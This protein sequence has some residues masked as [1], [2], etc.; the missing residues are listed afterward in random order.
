[1]AEQ[2]RNRRVPSEEDWG[3]R[4][5]SELFDLLTDS[6]RR[7]VLYRLHSDGACQLTELAR[8]IASRESDT[9]SGRVPPDR[10]RAVY[11]DLYRSHIPKLVAANVVSYSEKLGEVMLVETDEQFS[12]CLDAA[13]AL[14]EA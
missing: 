4:Q 5:V 9:T 13:A 12:D 14:E 10:I 11:L 8:E 3:R 2:R 7:Y 1:M 6:R